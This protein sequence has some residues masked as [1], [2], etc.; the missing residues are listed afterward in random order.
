MR[1]SF[2][3]SRCNVSVKG[4]NGTQILEQIKRDVNDKCGGNLI[5]IT[6]DGMNIDAVIKM[7]EVLASEIFGGV[8][9]FTAASLPLVVKE[10]HVCELQSRERI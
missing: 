8:K 6:Q 4:F 3:S 1:V 10:D 2:W 9:K 7:V 5:Y